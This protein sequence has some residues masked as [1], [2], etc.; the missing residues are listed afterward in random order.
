MN[1]LLLAAFFTASFAHAEEARNYHYIKVPSKDAEGLRKLLSSEPMLHN[2]EAASTLPKSAAGLAAF[3]NITFEAGAPFAGV[4]VTGSAGAAGQERDLEVK[5]DLTPGGAQNKGLISVSSFAEEPQGK[6]AYQGNSAACQQ[7]NIP[8]GRW[9]ELASWG[10]ENETLMLWAYNPSEGTASTAPASLRIEVK[11]CLATDAD[12]ELLKKATKE[13]RE[14]AV[15]WI[16]GRSKVYRESV[17][18]AAIGQKTRWEM[19]DTKLDAKDGAAFA[20]QASVYWEC[21]PTRQDSGIDSAWK[22]SVKQADSKNDK[23]AIPDQT[24]TLNTTPQTWDYAPID[25]G[26]FN[27]MI[28]KISDL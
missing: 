3:K 15:K 16:L 20:D 6:K 23:P 9:L 27:L 1:R 14:K 25:G 28:F 10:R 8:E 21:K 17:A 5:L 11:F 22:I 19:S 2:P 18:P 13:T 26:K 24:L 4:K 7:L 12:I